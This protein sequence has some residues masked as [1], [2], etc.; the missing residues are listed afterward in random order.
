[1]VKKEGVNLKITNIIN[2]ALSTIA[3]YKW[4]YKANDQWKAEFTIEGIGYY[5]L[6]STDE[7]SPLYWDV[8][9]DVTNAVDSVDAFAPTGTG[10][11]FIVFS[12]VISIIAEFANSKTKL[13]G[14]K[15][16]AKEPSRQKLYDKII[17][18]RILKI[19]PGW[20][21]QVLTRGVHKY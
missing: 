7:D 3:P 14:F 13:F 10:N 9:F 15:F 17:A 16:T 11:A 2:E 19:L 6:F 20:S 4:V 12:T 18:P 1:M 5:I 21:L 8:V